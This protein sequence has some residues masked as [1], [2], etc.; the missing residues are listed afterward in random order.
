MDKKG[1]IESMKRS[2]ALKSKNVIAAFEKVKREDFCLEE[3]RSSAYED[4]P[5]PIIAGQTI[6][7][8][9]TVAMMTEALKP[10]L[11]D[12]ILEIGAGSGYQAAI[13]SEIVGKKGIL[14]T[15]E[16]IKELVEFARRNLKHHGNVV[17]LEGDGSGGLKE[18]APFDGIIVTAGAPQIPEP[19]KKQLK[20]GGRIVIPVGDTFSQN[21]VVIERISKDK[22]E[23][24][25]IG[26]FVF[27]PLIGKHAW[28]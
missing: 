23:T 9:T 21:I 14:F 13:L 8:P 3:Y 18:E 22:F 1:L 24:T 2:G 11:G 17:V 20:I 4:R 28:K 27:V 10:K 16:R 7:Q 15:I 19:L 6:S 26:P 12:K 25:N 5:L